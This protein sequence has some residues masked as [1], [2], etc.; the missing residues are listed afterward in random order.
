MSRYCHRPFH[1]LHIDPGGS[2]RLCAWMDARVGDLTK[3]SLQT[4]WHSKEAQVLRDAI[5]QGNFEYCRAQSC[6]FL[7]N[8]ALP[9]LPEAEFE[10]ACNVPNQP[11]MF[12]V[13]CDF[14]CNHS[15]PS[16]RKEVFRPEAEYTKTLHG[17]LEKIRPALHRATHIST[18]GN[19]DA[20][21]SPEIMEMLEHLHPQNP[22]CNVNLETNGTLFDEGHWQR[23]SHLGKCNFTVTVTP[24]SFVESTFRYLNGGHD[25]YQKIMHNMKFMSELRKQGAIKEFRVSIV[26]QDRN[27]LELPSFAERCLNEFEVDQVIVKPLY[28]WFCLKPDEYWF[29]D[30]LNPLHPD[31]AEFQEMLKAPILKDPRVYFWGGHHD[32]PAERH[33]AYIFEEH[34]QLAAKLMEPGMPQKLADGL[35]QRGATSCVIYGDMD[36]GAILYRVLTQSDLPVHGF[37]ARDICSETRCGQ[38]ILP[39]DQY[40]N[41]SDEAVIVLHYD[42]MEKIVRDL[43]FLGCKGAIVSVKELVESIAP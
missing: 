17:I 34:M 32:H 39:M 14:T 27:F 10:A 43:H 7:E 12:N 21:A 37:V 19:G 24:N 28:R 1:Y 8:D 38:K 35:R 30:V 4:I 26:V 33:P 42:F 9:D 3:D 16:C 2:C 23:I 15:C 18:C 40:K 22:S 11:D 13:A 36:L 20:F 29:K 25:T 6:P 5:Q 31:H 41:V